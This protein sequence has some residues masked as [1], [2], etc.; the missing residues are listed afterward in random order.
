[1]WYGDRARWVGKATI[2]SIECDYDMNQWFKYK[3]PNHK[4]GC[5]CKE[6]I[7]ANNNPMIQVG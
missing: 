4:C 7:H 5:E 1:M 2:M 6:K 3:S